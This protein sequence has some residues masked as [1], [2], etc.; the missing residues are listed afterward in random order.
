MKKSVKSILVLVCI[1]AVVAVVLAAVNSVTAPI[2]KANSDAKANEALLVVLPDG[3]SFEKL[4]LGSYTLPA[5]V[6]EAYR[7]SNGGYVVKLETAGFSTGLVIMCGIKDGAVTGSVC[8]ESNE[9]WGLEATFGEKVVGS[10]VDTIVDVE[11]GATSKTVNGYRDAV[12]DAL[13][14]AIVLGGGSVDIRTEE[15][16]LNDNLSAALPAANGEFEKLFFVESVEGVDAVYNAKNNAGSVYVIGESFIAV[17]ASG[18]VLGA[19]T[20]EE[21]SVVTAAYAI[22]AASEI[23][24]VDLG[25]YEGISSGV[26]S[27][28][29]TA[30]GN[31][32]IEIEAKGYSAQNS[33]AP[34]DMRKP[35]AIRVSLTAD[36]VVIDTLTLSHKET[37][38]IGD[39]CA[40]ESYYGQFD[41]KNETEV[42]ALDTVAGATKT[43]KAYKNAIL[44]AFNTVKILEEVEA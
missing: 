16:I 13:N 2:I 38:N 18:E 5:T 42:G 22:L 12:K 25:A 15:E 7:A 34:A 21:S 14:A 43:T 17:N 11:A 28:K 41:G 1:C 8:L 6:V 24:D 33:Y 3:G 36:G 20:A 40:K 19:P 32:V 39:V 10:T 30:S 9:T 37:E 27:V 29:K 35:I 4:D 26:K 31:Y 44:E 23:A